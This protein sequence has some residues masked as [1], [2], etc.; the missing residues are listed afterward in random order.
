M[1]EGKG[2]SYF[3][4]CGWGR[5]FCKANIKADSWMLRKQLCQH[6]GEKSSQVLNE[7]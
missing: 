4:L 5:V 6:F 2:G 7:Q 1:I 3:R